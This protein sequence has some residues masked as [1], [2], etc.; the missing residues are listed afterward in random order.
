MRNAM[1][2]NNLEDTS[3]T[4]PAVTLVYD[5]DCPNLPAA[6]VALRE[7]FERAGL[8]PRWIEYNRA[9]PGTPVSLLRYGSPTILID[10]VDVAGDA[11]QAVG[12]SCRVYPSERGLCGVPSVES[13]ARAIVHHRGRYIPIKSARS[14]I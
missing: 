1:T 14:M 8:E 6:R 3:A 5:A 2:V 11:E 12:A 10:G 7:A 9:R 4:K 13:I